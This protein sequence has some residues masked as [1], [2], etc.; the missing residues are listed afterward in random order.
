M[1]GYHFI[2]YSSVDAAEF[3]LLLCDQLA[4]G[5]PKY[6]AWLDKREITPGQDWDKEIAE[7][8]KGCDSLLFVMTADSVEDESVCKPEWTH[9][10]KYK[11][12]IVPL[13]LH[14]QVDPPFRI[15]NRQYIDFTQGFDAGVARLRLFLQE[16]NSPKGLL[17]TSK[18]RLADAQRDVRRATDPVEQ[19]RIQDEMTELLKQIAQLQ[20][21]VHNPE[22]VAKRVEENITRGLERERQPEK[23]VGVVGRTKFVNPPPGLAPR[24]FQNRFIETKLIGNFLRDESKRLLTVVGRPGVGKTAMVCRVLKSLEQGRLPAGGGHLSVD[25]IVYLSGSG[26]RPVAVRNI[27]ADLTKLLPDDAAA[28][29]DA[30]YKNAPATTT[31]KMTALTA[32]FSQGPTVLLLDNFEDVIDSATETIRDSELDEALRALLNLPHHTVKV[33]ITT[34]VAPRLLGLVQPGRQARIELDTGLES[35]FA[36][37]ILRKMD[38]DGKLGLKTAP[39]E[40]LEEAR[41]RTLGFPRAL[42]AL[43]AILSADRH[44]SLEEVLGN[45][46]KLLPENVVDALVGEAFNRLDSTAQKVMQA[47]SVYGRPVTA[48]S[49]DYLLQPYVPGVDSAPVLNRLVNMHFVRKETGRYYLHPV[50]RAYARSRLPQREELELAESGAFYTEGAL[51]QRGAEYYRQARKAPEN[52]RS[53]EDLSPQLGEFDLRYAAGDYDRA[54]AVLQEIDFEHLQMWG[55]YRLVTELH[56]R[57]QG[58][59]SDAGLQQASVGNLGT[60]YLR[61][62]QYKRAITCYERALSI[63]R[64]NNNRLDEGTWLGSLGN[65]YAEGGQTSRAIDYYEKALAIRREVGDRAGEGIDLGNLAG[66]YEVLGQTSRAIE[67]YEKALTIH[68]ET[69]DRWSEA[70]GLCNLGDLYAE[71]G[72]T[73]EAMQYLDRALAIAREV[74]YRLAEAAAYTNIGY[75]YLDQG[76]WSEAT[77]EF[78]QAI[79][80][81]DDTANIQFQQSGRRGL[82]QAHLYQDELAPAREMAETGARYNFPLSNHKISAIVAVA[83]VR[84]GDRGAAREAFATTLNQATEVL[85]QNPQSYAALDTKGL[86]LCGLALCETSD[87]VAAATEAYKA[88]RAINSAAGIVGRVVRLF[89]ALAKADT[90]GILA[91]VRAE[92]TGTQLQ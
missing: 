3:A 21:T 33:I 67:Y 73:R 24:Y 60:A 22:G 58:K 53:L 36:E 91:Q 17:R 70:L 80:I 81:A 88:A 6:R 83:T 7:A 11:K 71:L 87:H 34:R 52:W 35:P 38:A 45:A 59:I 78:Q 75:V 56:E 89:D 29:L 31:A 19:K 13:K 12:P 30:V 51:L 79:E 1:P 84:Q 49:V 41:R 4:A 39:D 20:Q 57:L 40:L 5:P 85:T 28:E 68:R 48:S 63:A 61:M 50:D 9:A 76:M 44:T 77:S 2:S 37:D 90:A 66:E 72:R 69:Q 23:P 62:G 46:E 18:D 92:A 55:H 54:A 47:L 74:G 16:L 14:R 26:S 8:I 65:C 86:A 25:G 43:F 32:R 82:A 15:A 27:Y 64:G 42:E 10:L